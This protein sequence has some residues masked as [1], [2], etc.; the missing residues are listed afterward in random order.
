M[1]QADSVFEQIM[2]QKRLK[3]VKPET[4]KVQVKSI[5]KKK[6]AQEQLSELDVQFKKS[7]AESIDRSV[8]HRRVLGI[9]RDLTEIRRLKN[10]EHTF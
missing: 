1:H 10:D 7:V 5:H 2:K 3:P 4:T 8:L 9:R 6:L